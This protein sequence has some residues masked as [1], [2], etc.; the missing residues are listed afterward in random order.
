M[1][2]TITLILILTLIW[3]VLCGGGGYCP[4]FFWPD[5]EKNNRMRSAS[6]FDAVYSMA[7]HDTYCTVATTTRLRSK[8]AILRRG[9]NLTQK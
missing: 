9:Q 4:G 7:T 3:G 5:T 1:K 2:I 8:N 6:K